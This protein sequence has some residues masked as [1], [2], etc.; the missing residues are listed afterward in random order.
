[1]LNRTLKQHENYPIQWKHDLKLS[2]IV[3]T[4][5]KNYNVEEDV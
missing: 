4:W 2:D 5:S 3:E 1:M